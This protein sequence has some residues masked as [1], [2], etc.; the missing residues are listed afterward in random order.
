MKAIVLNQ[1][2]R[3]YGRGFAL[4]RVSL[5][6]DP[7]S[8][9]VILGG[10]GAGKTTL[11]NILATLDKPTYGDVLYDDWD[12]ETFAKR[13]RRNIGW[14]SH[15]SLLYPELTGRENLEFFARMYGMDDVSAISERWIATVGLTESADRHVSTYSRGMRQ[16]LSVARALLHKPALLLLDEPLT[17]LDRHA[18]QEMLDLFSSLRD[19]G[20]IVVMITHDFELPSQFLDRLVILRSGKL[21]YSGEVKDAEDLLEKF[22]DF[23]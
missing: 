1:V 13:G 16:R 5:R 21:T 12:W 17:G 20:R 10:N 15:D 9:T 22:R 7:G 14:V 11:I 19:E 8:T 2:S 23:A 3:A 4:H 6:L 18:R